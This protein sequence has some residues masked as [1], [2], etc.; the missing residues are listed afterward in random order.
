MKS[1]KLI[2]PWKNLV[3][4]RLTSGIAVYLDDRTKLGSLDRVEPV[5]LNLLAA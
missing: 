2:L 3:L 5:Q 4:D 1:K